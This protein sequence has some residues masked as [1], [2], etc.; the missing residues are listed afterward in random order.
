VLHKKIGDPIQIGESLA[1][2]H[3]NSEDFDQVMSKIYESILIQAQSVT[4][5]PLLVGEVK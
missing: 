3:A 4:P 1:T 5:P 2:I